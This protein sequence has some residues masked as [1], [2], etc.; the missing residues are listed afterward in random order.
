MGSRSPRRGF[1]NCS[2]AKLHLETRI[3]L[4]SGASQVLPGV[5]KARWCGIL[6]LFDHVTDG[7]LVGMYTALLALRAAAVPAKPIEVAVEEGP[8]RQ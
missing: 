3:P 8:A 4:T 6:L 7:A 5:S 1:T 2:P